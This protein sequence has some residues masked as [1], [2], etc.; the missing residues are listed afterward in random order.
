M[1]QITVRVEVADLANLKRV[2]L[3]QAFDTDQ[4]GLVSAR[5]V[6]LKGGMTEGQFRAAVG[7]ALVQML[8]DTL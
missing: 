6:E 7:D 2:A 1:S 4:P 5:F 3:L 8:D